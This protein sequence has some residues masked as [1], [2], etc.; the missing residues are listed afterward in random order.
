M[1]PMRCHQFEARLDEWVAGSLPDYERGRMDEH[2]ADCPACRE[3]AEASRTIVDAA[4]REALELPGDAYFLDLRSRMEG[5][6]A[7]R[8]R[9]LP[10]SLAPLL[11]PGQYASL[12]VA[13][14]CT[15]L[16]LTVFPLGGIDNIPRDMLLA[17]SRG[18]AADPPAAVSLQR[19]HQQYLEAL[20]LLDY[21]I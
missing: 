5:E 17:A 2:E 13:A 3:L 20:E 4:H 21:S 6:I 11:S 1:K 7:I 19:N 18:T 9:N 15:C 16:L 10:S 8:F 14:V 12:T